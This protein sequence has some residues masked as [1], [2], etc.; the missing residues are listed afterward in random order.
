MDSML[1]AEQ[2]T[3]D[4]EP[5]ALVGAPPSLM[6]IPEGCRFAERC[7]VVRTETCPHE[8]QQLR[9]VGERLVRCQY[10]E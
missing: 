6:S 4:R 9:T 10:A 1:L 5:V 3:R 2:G 8:K 7:P